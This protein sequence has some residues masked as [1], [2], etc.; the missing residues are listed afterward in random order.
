MDVRSRT[1]TIPAGA[2]ELP[3]DL[4]VPEPATGV[5]LFA[6]GSGS[7]RHS[8]RNVAVAHVLNRS[9]LATV[10]VDLLT[11]AEDQ[12]D[13]RTAELRFD[14]DLLAGRLA[15]IVDWLAAEE[16]YRA[17]PVGLFGASTGA[18]A[19]LVA[20]AERPGLVRAVVSRGG[21]PDLAG[22]A[23]G[24]VRAPT[25]L[26]VGGRDEEVIALNEQAQDA[27]PDDA[28]LTVIPGA[29]HLFEEPGTL[30]QV[31]HEAATW[32]TTHLPERT[33]FG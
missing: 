23:L 4:L 32:F 15:G 3:A 13:E 25:L 8:P 11:P 2:V 22:P 14:I 9:A 1:V 20:A 29:T 19:A 16:P 24:R 31:A 7:S 28:E 6:H 33:H 27:L 5:V 30:E 10:L 17:L 21:R 18:A 12:V 26:L